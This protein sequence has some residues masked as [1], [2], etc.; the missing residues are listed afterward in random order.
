MC[1][2]LNIYDASLNSSATISTSIVKNGTHSLN[3]QT[4]NSMLI[5]TNN[6]NVGLN[7]FTVACWLYLKNNG[8]SNVTTIWTINNY[9]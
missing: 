6:Y 8:Q 9:N 5:N 4:Y 1:C 3:T 2:I 7:G